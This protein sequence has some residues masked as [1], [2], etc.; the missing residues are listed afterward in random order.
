MIDG[1]GEACS[2]AFLRSRI[3]RIRSAAAVCMLRSVLANVQTPRRVG[4]H[5]PDLARSISTA[6]GMTGPS[7][8]GG[9]LPLGRADEGRELM[10]FRMAYRFVPAAA[11]RITVA[12]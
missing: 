10:S 6:P 3:L 4:P 11:D 7:S 5:Q 2:A 8:L 1:A 12:S 9:C